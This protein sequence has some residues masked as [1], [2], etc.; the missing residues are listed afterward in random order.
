MSVV[1]KPKA[2]LL[3]KVHVVLRNGSGHRYLLA[4]KDCGRPTGNWIP[5]PLYGFTNIADMPTA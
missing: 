4:D 2:G 1:R 5:E 3:N